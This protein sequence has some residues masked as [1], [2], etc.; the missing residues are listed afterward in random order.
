MCLLLH[1]FPQIF[2]ARNTAPTHALFRFSFHGSAIAVAT[3]AS[4]L[5][6]IDTV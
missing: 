6:K 5:W 1:K 2:L 3:G 4:E